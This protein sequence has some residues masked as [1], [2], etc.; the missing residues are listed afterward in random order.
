MRLEQGKAGSIKLFCKKSV[1]KMKGR[2]A[3]SLEWMT[4]DAVFNFA[5]FKG[6]CRISSGNL[7]PIFGSPCR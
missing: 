5:E 6:L 7:G 1:H 3:R 4:F 2:P